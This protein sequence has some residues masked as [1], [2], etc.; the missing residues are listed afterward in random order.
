MITEPN[1]RLKG[2]LI[3]KYGKLTTG[4]MDIPIDYYRLSRIISGIVKP[5]QEEK[6]RIAW[7]L[8]EPISELFGSKGANGGPQRNNRNRASL[9]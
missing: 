7:K 5:S 3:Q 8:Q 9:F 2:M 6:R 4:A 1:L